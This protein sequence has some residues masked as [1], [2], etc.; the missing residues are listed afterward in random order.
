MSGSWEKP[1]YKYTKGKTI[2][3]RL[4]NIFKINPDYGNIW[5]LSI[6]L[7]SEEENLLSGKLHNTRL[8]CY[9]AALQKMYSSFAS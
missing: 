8:E 6:H 3:I 5:P 4:E 1:C 9:I 2:I 7:H